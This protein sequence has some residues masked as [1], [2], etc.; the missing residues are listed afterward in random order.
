NIANTDSK[1]TTTTT[2]TGPVTT[3]VEPSTAGCDADGDGVPD[4]GAP[5]TC[6]AGSTGTTGVDQSAPPPA[7]VYSIQRKKHR[8]TTRGKSKSTKSTPKKR[9][10]R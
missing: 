2:Q 3:G 9:A 10:K 5:S 1:N 7:T 6:S 8:S 4:P